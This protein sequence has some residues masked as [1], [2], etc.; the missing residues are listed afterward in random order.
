VA[1]VRVATR[2]ADGTVASKLTADSHGP[3]FVPVG[4]D[5]YVLVIPHDLTESDGV[6]ELLEVIRSAE[7]RIAGRE[8][9]GY[10][11]TRAGESI[12]V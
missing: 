5:Q 9:P 3:D 11:L 10:D 1:I 4:R 8:F 2:E 7:F 6:R 12:G